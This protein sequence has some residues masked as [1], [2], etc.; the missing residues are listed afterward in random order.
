MNNKH[1]RMMQIAIG[2]LMLCACTA[3]GFGQ[4]E[5]AQQTVNRAVQAYNNQWKGDN[6]K[7]W[8][9]SGKIVIAGNTKG[10]LDFTMTVKQKDK[11]K[12]I[13]KTADGSKLMM[14]DGSDGKKSWHATGP[15][16]GN[17]T[18]PFSGSATGSIV[19]FIESNT[20]RAIARLFDD[21][22][23]LSDKGKADKKH[24]PESASSEVIEVKHKNGNTTRYYIDNKSSLVTRLEFETGV[25]YTLLL[26]NKQ[27]PALA[28]FVFSDYRQVDGIPTPFK[29][30]VYSGLTQIEEM[31]FTS[32]QYNTGVKDEA[33]VP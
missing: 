7:D 13:V 31:R 5:T 30:S 22:N 18:G 8:V 26:S 24:A 12:R 29:I 23:V 10:P 28:S 2:L 15:F 4:Q 16:S 6:I 33:F 32:V 3:I 9:G 20:T 25:F 1:I 27:Y 21:D 14:N 19:H 11:V 17:A